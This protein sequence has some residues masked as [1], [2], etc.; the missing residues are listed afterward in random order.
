M[1][2]NLEKYKKDLEKLIAKGDLLGISMRY[3]CFPEEIEKALGNKSDE[4]IKAL[5]NFYD[6]YQTWYSEAKVVIKQLLPDRLSDFVRHYEK[7][8]TR[9]EI[10]MNLYNGH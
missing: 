1:P 3:E 9:K 5:P 7:P 2:S 10:N 4:L 6:E 8:K